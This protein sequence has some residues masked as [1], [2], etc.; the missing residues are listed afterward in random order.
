MSGDRLVADHGIG[1]SAGLCCMNA[2]WSA[3]MPAR[4]PVEHELPW[5]KRLAGLAYGWQLCECQL[6]ARRPFAPTSGLKM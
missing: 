2:D 6:P 3:C 1:T 5:P 4:N